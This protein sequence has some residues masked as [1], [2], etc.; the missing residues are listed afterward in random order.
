[1]GRLMQF[2]VP[3]HFR[4]LLAKLFYSSPRRTSLRLSLIYIISCATS[5]PTAL[6]YHSRLKTLF[7]G[8]ISGPSR[9]MESATA[10]RISIW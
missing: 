4:A 7:L 9:P 10:R 2:Y 8:V 1:M 5:F 3:C 6:M